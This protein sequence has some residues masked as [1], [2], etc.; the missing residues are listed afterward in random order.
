M[1]P[2]PYTEDDL[3]QRT[4]AEYLEERLGWKS[5]YAH[6]R[7]DFGPDGLL[8][9]RSDHDVVLTRPLRAALA[10]L[11][12][13]LPEAAYDDA[14]R[15]LV[16]T[17]ASKSIVAANREKY[18]L[19]RDGVSV[20]FVDAD[21]RPA[22]RRLRVFD[23]ETPE[24]N[25]YLCVRE[26]WIRG[27]LYRRRADLVGFVNGLPL[28]FVECKN[29]H[30]NLRVAFE[31]NYRDYRDTIP[32]LFHHNAIVMFANGESAKIGSV[33]A[34]WGHFHEWKR[35]AEEESGAVDM[36]TLLKG[37]CDR[38]NFLD[39]FENF[40]LF[41]DSAGSVRKILARNHQFLGVNRAVEA[42]RD[43]KRR[44]GR[45][46]VFWHTQGA[47]K[48]YSMAFLTRKVHRKLSGA[49]TFLILT[50]RADLDSQIYQTF[51]GCGIADH[52]RDPCRAA[53]GAHLRELL[54]EH[55]SH[56]FSLIQ[57]FHE[58]VSS[59]GAY[60]RRDDVIVMTDEAH[61][62]QYGTLALNLR[63]ALPNA[64]YLG[65]TGTPL[66]QEDEITRQVFGEYV[67]TY[68]FQRAV[69]DGATVPLYYESGG[70]RL[71]VTTRDLNE[72]IAEKLE[73]LEIED[74]DVAQKLER[75]LG[76]QYHVL[77]ADKRLD[78]IARDFARHASAGWES[79]KAMLVCVD[80]VTCGRMHD[81]ITRYWDARIGQLERKRGRSRDEQEEASLDR[82]IRW[83]RET[84]I[85][86]VVSEEQGE[87][88][89]FHRWGLDVRPH[90]RLLKEGMELPEAMQRRPEFRNIQRMRVEDAFKAEEHPFRVAIVCAMWLTGFDVPCLST[91][92]L[93]KPL[94]AH[95]LMQ[96]IARANRVNE[97]KPNGLI[98]DYCGVL[99]P[100]RRALATWAAPSTKAGA[101]PVQPV[102]EM[103][104]ALAE[105]IRTVRSFLDERG[106]PLDNV[107]REAGFGRNAAIVACK[108]AVNE[109]DETRKRFEVLCREVFRWFRTCL[110]Y[111]QRVQR[112]RADR[113]AIHIVYQSLQ[114][115][116]QRADTGRILRELHR[117]VDAAVDTRGGV[118]VA[119]SGA[120]DLSGLDFERL[121]KEFERNRTK[122]T[123]IQELKQAVET[124][125]R[126][127]LARNPRRADLQARFDEIVA[128]YNREKDRAT[129]ERTFDELLK[130]VRELDREESRAV[131]EG[132][133]EE[134]L[135]LFDL[136]RKDRLTGKERARVKEAAV[137]LLEVV[138]AEVRRVSQWRE[139]EATRDTVRSAIRDFLWADATGLP[140]PRYS[141]AEVQTRVDDVYRHVFRAYPEV[142]SPY[143]ETDAA[144]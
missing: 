53:S 18:D 90:R 4:T 52:D 37:V 134:S 1:T 65:F 142:P 34:E 139:K 35:L 131:R 97:G 108:E 68:D 98:V 45:L 117:L 96:A 11:N 91:L 7:E 77:T 109:K 84:R 21:G 31:E 101:L 132:L 32:H 78:Q 27:D 10:E 126:K 42:V 120:Y 3:V 28:L 72:R 46:G 83:M 107:L 102:K 58:E 143:Y 127:L 41:D 74:V 82:Q 50:D 38:R 112:Y 16:A 64:S 40:I 125:L 136:L 55:K 88:E 22:N 23:F 111:P 75:Q 26:L 60:S 71:G 57:K 105:A 113:D 115:D 29:I 130:L 106:A 59:D 104:A 118:G 95:A 133:D 121:K 116:R 36:E 15:Q 99:G 47:G 8:G 25:D 13:G 79:G 19:L 5:V 119:G 6:N 69:E 73:E 103:L 70:D 30:R 89:A 123:R 141:D 144:A 93:D 86:V 122:R 92:Y 100:L 76:S 12:P 54:G 66:F 110:R 129:I 128:A 138:K 85:A 80:K 63:D 20:T 14:V 81:K 124:R 87:V 140:S 43:R 33:T 51:A 61:R 67:S 9:R 17:D 62:T 114:Q 137:G 48:S 2:R 24:N 94:R 39:L 49:F 56:L 135:A 44:K